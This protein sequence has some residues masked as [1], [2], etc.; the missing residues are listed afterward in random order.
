MPD[1]PDRMLIMGGCGSVETNSLLNL[2][3]ETGGNFIDKIHWYAKDF[4]KPKYQFQIKKR[5]DVGVKHL[6]DS[7]AFIEHS[8]ITD[9]IYNNFD[10]YKP[11]RNRKI[12]IVF[13]DMI[14]DYYD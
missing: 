2:I 3:K 12:L 5:E 11:N 13:G 14:A 8:K 4:K 7:K 9:D 10:D 6:N 1:H